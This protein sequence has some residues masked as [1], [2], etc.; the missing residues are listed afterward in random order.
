M[1]R[2]NTKTANY[3]FKT[4]AIS[5]LMV[6]TSLFTLSDI[7]FTMGFWLD[8]GVEWPFVFAACNGF[9]KAPFCRLHGSFCFLFGHF[10][11]TEIGLCSIFDIHLP[12]PLLFPNHPLN[13]PIHPRGVPLFAPINQWDES[14]K[15]W[16]K[17]LLESP[18]PL[19]SIL[20]MKFL[21]EI[22]MGKMQWEVFG[23]LLVEKI[24]FEQG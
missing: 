12:L 9:F 5:L 22:Y 8:V 4:H 14:V 20:S 18:P 16:L 15:C 2:E 21:L 11:I 7:A 17:L 3:S 6:I 1:R 23:Y 13:I 24:F 19:F 10:K